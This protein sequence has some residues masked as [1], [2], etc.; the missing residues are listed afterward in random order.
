MK[1]VHLWQVSSVLKCKAISAM[2]S[3]DALTYYS[4]NTQFCSSSDEVANAFRQ[5][6]NKTNKCSRILTRR[7]SLRLTNKIMSDADASEM[8]VFKK[9]PAN[10][11]F[12][13]A[14]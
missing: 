6:C 11:F 3:S 13:K 9:L 5:W 1:M 12:F 2:L 14:A 10:C 4:S 7:Q 8:E